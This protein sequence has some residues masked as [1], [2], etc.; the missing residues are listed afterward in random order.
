MKFDY[1]KG[2]PIYPLPKFVSPKKKKKYE[3]DAPEVIF[4]L[5]KPSKPTKRVRYGTHM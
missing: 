2:E 1:N 3:A 5:K 4:E